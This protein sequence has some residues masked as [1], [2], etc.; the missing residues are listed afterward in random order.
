[1]PL[2]KFS[3]PM[4]LWM[5]DWRCENRGPSFI[6]S[7]SRQN[8]AG[9]EDVKEHLVGVTLRPGA[10]GDHFLP[11]PLFERS[12]AVRPLRSRDGISAVLFFQRCGLSA[13]LRPPTWPTSPR[14]LPSTALPEGCVLATF[15][16]PAWWHAG[17]ACS[18][19]A[20]SKASWPASRFLVSPRLV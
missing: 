10:T 7:E 6:I 1:M 11:P 2:P 3:R 19:F 17:D 12:P 9:A 16:P 13:G 18:S 5:M 15:T 14:V 20:S 8:A 4:S